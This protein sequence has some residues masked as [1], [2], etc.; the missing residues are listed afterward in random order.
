MRT[1]AD[2]LQ[3]LA[4]QINT[5][6]EDVESFLSAIPQQKNLHVKGC[7]IIDGYENSMPSPLNWAKH[8][9]PR[10]ELCIWDQ[11]AVL[12]KK[13]FP[14]T[15][16][17]LKF[18]VPQKIEVHQRLHNIIPK[19][20][21][22]IDITQGSNTI[23]IQFLKQLVHNLKNFDE[24]LILLNSKNILDY[25]SILSSIR[26]M[27]VFVPNTDDGTLKAYGALKILRNAGYLSKTY[28]L[29]AASDKDFQASNRVD[30]IKNVAKIHLGLDLGHKRMVLSSIGEKT[31]AGI[32]TAPESF[33]PV[34]S[35]DEND[36]LQILSE[37]LLYS[38]PGSI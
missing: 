11:A 36:F 3:Q 2:K 30:R 9:A 19:Q 27:Y 24:L 6:D 38:I 26:T 22:F 28:L 21:N 4:E 13:L 31:S 10:G 34:Y 5:T 25:A 20:E 35:E 29:E 15:H 17:T 18:Q 1:Q 14:K 7:L 16:T 23:K 37:N 12:D 33:E 8:L 32:F